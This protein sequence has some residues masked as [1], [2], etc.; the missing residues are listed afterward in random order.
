MKYLLG[1]IQVPLVLL[2]AALSSHAHAHFIGNNELEDRERLTRHSPD[3]VQQA[4]SPLFEFTP[5]RSSAKGALTA[6]SDPLG[7]NSDP[8]LKLYSGVVQN[9]D[10]LENFQARNNHQ[11]RDVELPAG[12]V[13]QNTLVT[14]YV[15]RFFNGELRAADK[16]LTRLKNSGDRTWMGLPTTQETSPL[17]LAGFG[18]V[19]EMVKPRT[20]TW[21]GCDGLVRR[22][23]VMAKAEENRKLG[24]KPPLDPRYCFDI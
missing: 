11:H 8:S 2:I 19:G 10:L 4:A 3:Q 15:T 23:D 7:L 17:T 21:I 18:S 12:I 22:M 13:R 20:V 16:S 1:N 24:K 9:G 6:A 14:N 5:F